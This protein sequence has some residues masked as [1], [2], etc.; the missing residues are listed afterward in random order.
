MESSWAA[1]EEGV[2]E[3]V[4]VLKGQQVLRFV[5]YFW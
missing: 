2:L 1:E 5:L 4:E 3:E